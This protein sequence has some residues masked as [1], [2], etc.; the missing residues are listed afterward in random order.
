MIFLRGTAGTAARGFRRSD[1]RRS[2]QPATS[3]LAILLVM[4]ASL[5]GH[6]SAQALQA[7]ESPLTIH[8]TVINAATNAPIG[9]ARVS[10][11]DNRFASLT[12]GEGHF[13][14]ALPKANSDGDGNFSVA[15]PY[16][17][18]PGGPV[19]NLWLMA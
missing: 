1:S 3:V 16:Q 7:D 18:E 19:Q 8:G 15:Q 12:D 10:S 2:I 9:R 6:A 17:A 4:I 11:A 5:P 13:E 14:F